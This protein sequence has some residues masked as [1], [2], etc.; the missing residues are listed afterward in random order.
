MARKIA[1]LG[2]GAKRRGP[3][4]RVCLVDSVMVIV[5]GVGFVLSPTDSCKVA[6]NE[7]REIVNHGNNV[8]TTLVVMPYPA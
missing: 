5:N 8:A 6:H 2:T 1:A 7:V 3:D 4:A